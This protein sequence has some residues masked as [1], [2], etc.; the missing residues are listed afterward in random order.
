V[1]ASRSAAASRDAREALAIGLKPYMDLKVT[2]YGPPLPVIALARLIPPGPSG[3]GREWPAKNVLLR[4]ELSSEVRGFE[5]TPTL[6]PGDT[7]EAVIGQPNENWPPPTGVHVE[8]TVDWSDEQDVA[9][10]RK[11]AL[12]DL[13]PSVDPGRPHLQNYQ[14][15]PTE[16][17]TRPVPP[18]GHWRLTRFALW[19]GFDPPDPPSPQPGR[20]AR[21]ARWAGFDPP[22]PR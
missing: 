18:A 14:E 17:I 10:Y 22:Y 8:A 1:S 15:L 20:L 16:R 2:H 6:A 19:A 11:R 5:S 7:L 9:S 21:F 4:F 13:F 12:G 3:L